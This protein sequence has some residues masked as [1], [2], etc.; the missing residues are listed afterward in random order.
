MTVFEVQATTTQAGMYLI[1]NW[2]LDSCVNPHKDH[3][4]VLDQARD[5]KKELLFLILRQSEGK[6]GF[7]LVRCCHA[8][9]FRSGSERWKCMGDDSAGKFELSNTSVLRQDQDVSILDLRN[10]VATSDICQQVAEDEALLKLLLLSSSNEGGSGEGG[11]NS[12]GSEWAWKVVKIA[13]SLSGEVG[14][15]RLDSLRAYVSLIRPQFRAVANE[16]HIEITI[17]P[18]NWGIIRDVKF[19]KQFVKVFEEMRYEGQPQWRS[20]Q[21]LQYFYAELERSALRNR[22]PLHLRASITSLEIAIR[23]SKC[24]EILTKA[25]VRARFKS[26]AQFHVGEENIIG[27]VDG[28]LLTCPVWPSSIVEGFTIDGRMYR[29]CIE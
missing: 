28:N 22:M 7:K 5:E 25:G 16:D 13:L 6:W 23:K 26:D 24:F 8:L 3:L 29:V 17:D 1:A 2:P 15:S 21:V 9:Y 10:L 4:F 27:E 12:E 20:S 18:T 19:I 14:C 11:N